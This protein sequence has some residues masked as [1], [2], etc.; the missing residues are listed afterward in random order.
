VGKKL[1]VDVSFNYV[2]VGQQATVLTRRAGKRGGLSAT[3]QMLAERD[4]QL[5]AE[6][7]DP[8]QLSI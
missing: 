5:N 3:Q 1:R 6:E 8:G 7:G 2:E 4:L